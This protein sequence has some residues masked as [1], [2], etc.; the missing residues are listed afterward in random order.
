[1]W[2]HNYLS[3]YN[4]FEVDTK[5][6]TVL[7][8][9]RKCK[10]NSILGTEASTRGRFRVHFS[11]R[12]LFAHEHLERPILDWNCYLMEWNWKL[13]SLQRYCLVSIGW[14]LARV[15][16]DLSMNIL[17]DWSLDGIAF[18][19]IRAFCCVFVLLSIKVL[20]IAN[21]KASQKW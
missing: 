11:W 21:N 8:R 2:L 14:N 15:I 20:Q 4:P 9:V 17:R 19:F 6:R 12:K 10:A 5:R 13:N 3:S 1:M 7:T 16:E 18:V